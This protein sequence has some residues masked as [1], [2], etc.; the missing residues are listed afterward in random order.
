MLK[1]GYTSGVYGRT[2]EYFNLMIVKTSPELDFNTYKFHGLYG[3]ENRVEQVLKD[4]GY[5]KIPSD[6]N[7][8]K[9]KRLDITKDTMS[10]STVINQLN[11][12]L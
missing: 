1:T 10:E 8:G 6:A 3:A 7:Y 11:Q 4:K 12:D 2:G 9:L 5:Q